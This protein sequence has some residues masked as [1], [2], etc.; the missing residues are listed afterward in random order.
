MHP[1]QR[2]PSDIQHTVFKVGEVMGTE[3]SILQQ[4]EKRVSFFP[5]I[6]LKEAWLKHLFQIPSG[7]QAVY[8]WQHL[9]TFEPNRQNR[10]LLFGEMG[11]H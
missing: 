5:V 8:S 1:D 10:E 6:F 9:K 3:A 4:P 7:S 11:P 2:S